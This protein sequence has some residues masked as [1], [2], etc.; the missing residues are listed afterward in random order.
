MDRQTAEAVELRVPGLSSRDS[1]VLSELLCEGDV[2]GDICPVSA[3]FK[4]KSCA[5]ILKAQD[6]IPTLGI[7]NLT[8][9]TSPS[10]FLCLVVSGEKEDKDAPL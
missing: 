10:L 3:E 9:T 8:Q 2:K 5:N 6:R 4:G 1:S 7:K